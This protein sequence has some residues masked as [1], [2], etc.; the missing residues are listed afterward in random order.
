MSKY[1]G[2]LRK[3]SEGFEW[4][5]TFALAI[6]VAIP[7]LYLAQNV[8]N[9]REEV[10]IY[11]ALTLT[12]RWN[13]TISTGYM[14]ASLVRSGQKLQNLLN[15]ISNF[16]YKLSTLSTIISSTSVGIASNLLNVFPICVQN[17]QILKQ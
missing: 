5:Y 12:N 17:E 15:Y 13:T 9:I 6:D 1:S 4:M 2:W 3:Q 7:C 16:M 14:Y 10:L 11:G 8:D